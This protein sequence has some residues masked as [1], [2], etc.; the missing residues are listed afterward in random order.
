[1]FCSELS[2]TAN[3]RQ[4]KPEGRTY[5]ARNLP[6]SAGERRLE[7]PE[8]LRPLVRQLVAGKHSREHALP[9]SRYVLLKE[10][11]KLCD[12]AKVQRV[13][14]HSLRGLHATLATSAG[15]S[16][17]AVSQALG[18]ASEAVTKRH[19]TDAAAGEKAAAGK[20]L[21]VL[22]GGRIRGNKL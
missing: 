18:H 15:S 11:H 4:S 5:F 16:S 6:G 13:C 10:L 7:I 2:E 14:V 3:P 20:V 1:M 12:A 19:Y 21:R 9:F 22:D 8:Q 17:H